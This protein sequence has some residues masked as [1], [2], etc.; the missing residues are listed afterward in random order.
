MTK[1]AKKGDQ[2]APAW[3]ATPTARAKIEKMMSNW[4]MTYDEALNYLV[5]RSDCPPIVRSDEP[6]DE[7]DFV[8][9]I[10]SI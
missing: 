7:Y 5:V 8:V 6:M 4:G 1:R 9:G 3:R 2:T 10:D